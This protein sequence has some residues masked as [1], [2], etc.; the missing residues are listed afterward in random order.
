MVTVINAPKAIA[1]KPVTPSNPFNLPPAPNNP[2]VDAYNRNQAANNQGNSN[3]SSNSGSS[4]GGSS[5]GGNSGVGSSPSSPTTPPPIN[6]QLAKDTGPIIPT[7]SQAT[8]DLITQQSLQTRQQLTQQD[9]ANINRNTG[10]SGVMTQAPN[11]QQGII[12]RIKSFISGLGSKGDKPVAGNVGGYAVNDVVA[13]T[14]SGRGTMQNPEITTQLNVA[15]NEKSYEQLKA[16]NILKQVSAPMVSDAKAKYQEVHNDIQQ[17]VL[18][19]EINVNTAKK[20]DSQAR[21]KITSE[22]NSKINQAVSNDADYQNQLKA[23]Q[24]I[25][26]KIAP[27]NKENYDARTKM[28]KFE[29][30]ER[31]VL[32]FVIPIV[33]D[34][35]Q[36]TLVYNQKTGF[37]ENRPT[38]GQSAGF[39]MDALGAAANVG[40]S[41]KIQMV[42]LDA[43]IARAAA[44]KSLRDLAKN[45][46][47]GQKVSVEM[48]GSMEEKNMLQNIFGENSPISKKLE[49]AEIGKFTS[50]KANGKLD[51]GYIAR[52]AGQNPE[53]GEGNAF[54]ILYKKTKAGNIKTARFVSQDLNTGKLVVYKFSMPSELKNIGKIPIEGMPGNPIEINEFGRLTGAKPVMKSVTK[55]NSM[56]QEFANKIQKII[57]R[58]NV[59]FE[60]GG[61]PR[62]NIPFINAMQSPEKNL[63]FK[64]KLAK[65]VIK[66]QGVRMEFMDKNAQE[67][68]SQINDAMSVKTGTIRR[69]V[70]AE[71]SFAESLAKPIEFEKFDVL[72]PTKIMPKGKANDMAKAIENIINPGSSAKALQ[73]NVQQIAPNELAGITK[74]AL[75]TYPQSVPKLKPQATEIN[76]KA[77]KLPGVRMQTQEQV[78]VQIDKLS[79]NN[80]AGLNFNDLQPKTKNKQAG[81]FSLIPKAGS[82]GALGSSS[83]NAMAQAKVQVQKM[84][85]RLNKAPRLSIPEI[86]GMPNPKITY[87]K[88]NARDFGIPPAPVPWNNQG[89]GNKDINKL[90]KALSKSQGAY[91]SDLLHA[92]FQE[93]GVKVTRKQ[94]KKLNATVFSGFESRPVLELDLGSSEHKKNTKALR[95]VNF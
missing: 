90:I 22:L 7:I 10:A 86:P 95:N 91:T 89:A 47:A 53:T 82:S 79:N 51:S 63:I 81:D 29:N 54:S 94:L 59:I 57:T 13:S 55:T 75:E 19:G 14:P 4:R 27:L 16:D 87:E 20:L 37:L 69:G 74:A 50:T 56:E 85:D 12:S 15:L 46:L 38:L 42:G 36:N 45:G 30:V 58:K 9:I 18:S 31:G 1:P 66:S 80:L 28:Q 23:I 44:Q 3:Q 62:G 64:A 39:V 32:E 34:V 41:A 33:K 61:K 67:V 73:V 84:I 76:L 70:S 65:P 48:I 40:V 52:L 78:N 77:L 83:S 11:Q 93:K 35:N 8:Q 5:G 43:A 72:K 92:A 6:S 68:V 60:I 24:N 17:R 21:D 49:T 88:L 71:K 26:A 25:D 2:I